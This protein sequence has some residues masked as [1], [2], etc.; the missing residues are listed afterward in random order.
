MPTLVVVG[1]VTFSRVLHCRIEDYGYAI[2]IARLRA[3][4][5][6][7]S[8]ELVGYLLSVP[9]AQRLDIHGVG[10]GRSQRFLT[11]A[12]MIAAVTAVLLGSAVGLV[13]ALVFHHLLVA[14]L[15]AGVLGAGTTLTALINVQSSTGAA[16]GTRMLA[17]A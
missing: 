13:A 16:R 5:F 4:Y 2:R 14:A 11:V 8:P 3:Y 12:A 9:P 10:G 7:N 17:E 1:L 15:V 6:E